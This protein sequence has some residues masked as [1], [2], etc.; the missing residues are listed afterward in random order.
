MVLHLGA[1]FTEALAA[2]TGDLPVVERV[3]DHVDL[4]RFE[5]LVVIWLLK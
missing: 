5:D 1:S 4:I 2:P 3:D